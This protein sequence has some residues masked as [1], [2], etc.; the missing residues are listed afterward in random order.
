MSD[1]RRRVQCIECGKTIIV[2]VRMEPARPQCC[3]ACCVSSG[4]ETE[5]QFR[6]FNVRCAVADRKEQSR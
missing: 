2:S 4:G 5:L 3:F 6:A 1:P